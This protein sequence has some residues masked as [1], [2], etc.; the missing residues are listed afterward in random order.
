MSKKYALTLS[1][2]AIAVAVATVAPAANAE[3]SGSLDI[4]NQYLW[5]GQTLLTAGT[6][7]GSL[8]YKHESGAYAGI[9]ASS[10][11]DKNEYDL[12]AGFTG[13]ISAVGYDVG[14]VSYH[15]TGERGT[16][17]GPDDLNFQELYLEL[18]L[19]DFA[20]GGFFGVGEFGDGATAADNRD[21]YYYAS[22]S[23]DQFGATVG[24]YAYDVSDEAYTHLDLSY[25]VI[26]N[27]TFTAS[28]I[29]DLDS[30][31]T[32]VTNSELKV[33]VAYSFPF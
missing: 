22:Y 31:N 18:S 1:T 17:F 32:A 28:K 20:V 33:V 15:Y 2:L 5:R 21:N 30:K 8:D 23:K 11:T 10:E 9:W 25:E 19:G 6:V 16:G 3:V 12:Y 24:H 14:A 29:L 26:E 27:L 13:D 7:S 4:A